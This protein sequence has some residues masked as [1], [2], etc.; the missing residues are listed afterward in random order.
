MTDASGEDARRPVQRLTP[1]RVRAVTFSRSPMG[2]EDS[3]RRRS[4]AS[5]SGLRT[6]SRHAT[7]RKRRCE[8]R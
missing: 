5:G 4:R 8:P 1:D 2:G 3:T 6:R 7:R